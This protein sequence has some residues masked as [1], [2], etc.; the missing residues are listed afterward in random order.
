[1]FEK[2]RIYLL[3]A[4][5]YCRTVLRL[6]YCKTSLGMV[7]AKSGQG[8]LGKSMYEKEVEGTTET[9]TIEDRYER[10]M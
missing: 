4:S 8:Q 6:S 7:I 2:D 1:M 10:V 3:F 9:L 5:I